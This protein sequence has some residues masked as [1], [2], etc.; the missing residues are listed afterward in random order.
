MVFSYPDRY[1]DEYVKE[2][3]ERFGVKMVPSIIFRIFEKNEINRKK[4]SFLI[5]NLIIVY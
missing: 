1:L 4:I 2:I 3:E 5:I